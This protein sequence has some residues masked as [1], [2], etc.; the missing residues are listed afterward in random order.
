LESLDLNEV[1]AKTLI[2]LV[3]AIGSGIGA[4]FMRKVSQLDK[5][6]KDMNAV[7]PKIRRI[8]ATLGIKGECD[9]QVSRV[10]HTNGIEAPNGSLHQQSGCTE[11]LGGGEE[12]GP[13]L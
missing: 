7:F 3:V 1:I 6:T 10:G 5:N 8:E 12:N 2:G 13:G 11:R 9:G 4:W